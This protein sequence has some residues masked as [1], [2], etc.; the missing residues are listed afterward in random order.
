ML[1]SA[2]PFPGHQKKL[3]W[4][5]ADEGGDGNYYR[6]DDPPMEGWLCPALLKYFAQAPPE[7]YVKAE[8]IK[9]LSEY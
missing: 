1:F 5:R 2:R 8:A 6:L 3:V 4:T 9:S 7:L